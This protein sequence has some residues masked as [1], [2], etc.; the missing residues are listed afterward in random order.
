MIAGAL[1]DKTFNL[2]RQLARNSN[3]RLVPIARSSHQDA[4]FD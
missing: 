1:Q 2:A 4:L 3:S